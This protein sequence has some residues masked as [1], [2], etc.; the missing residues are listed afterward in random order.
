MQ[1]LKMLCAAGFLTVSLTA[2]AGVQDKGD[3]MRQHASDEQVMVDLQ[4]KLAKDWT[5][6]SK[7]VVSGEKRIKSGQEDLDRGQKEIA[8]GKMLMQESERVFRE[9]FPH[10]NLV[11]VN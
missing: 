9:N 8:E 11:P 1:K 5:H 10:L 4:E 6:G 3:F 2:C 7:L